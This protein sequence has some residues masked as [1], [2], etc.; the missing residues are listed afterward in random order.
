MQTAFLAAATTSDFHLSRVVSRRVVL[1]V[2]APYDVVPQ[3]DQDGH[4]DN[5]RS[6][7]SC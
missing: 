1:P 6:C 4:R 7:K 5:E 3:T 2:A